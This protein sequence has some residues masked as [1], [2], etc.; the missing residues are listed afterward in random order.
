MTQLLPRL[1][2]TPRRFR[3]SATFHDKDRFIFKHRHPTVI[4]KYP[5]RIVLIHAHL[6]AATDDVLV[7]WGFEAHNTHRFR[8]MSLS[9]SPPMSSRLGDILMANQVQIRR[10]TC[11]TLRLFPALLLLQ[12]D[13]QSRLQCRESDALRYLCFICRPVHLP[14]ISEPC[15]RDIYVH[16]SPCVLVKTSPLFRRCS[17]AGACLLPVNSDAFTYAATASRLP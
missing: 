3:C 16:A 8:L 13:C 10:F 14:R 6:S 12:L 2:A 17:V 5:G 15:I 11:V 7:L 4:H 9:S 1:Q